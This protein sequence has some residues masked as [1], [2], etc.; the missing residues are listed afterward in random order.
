MYVGGGPPPNL[1]NLDTSTASPVGITAIF[2]IYTYLANP[3][4]SPIIISDN[5]CYDP[6][7]C[8]HPN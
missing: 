2:N 1:Y 6:L 5:N 8:L 4:P 3:V 7:V